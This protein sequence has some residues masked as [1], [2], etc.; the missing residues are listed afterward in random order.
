[1]PRRA[2]GHQAR[3]I[4]WRDQNGSARSDWPDIA[5]IRNPATNALVWPKELQDNS[6]FRR[7]GD[8]GPDDDTIGDFASL[9]QFRTDIVQLQQFLIRACDSPVRC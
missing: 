8:P 4:R 6:F 7:Q 3:D 5:T 1:V 2:F 9:K